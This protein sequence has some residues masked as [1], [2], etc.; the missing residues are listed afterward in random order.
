MLIKIVKINHLDN[1]YWLVP[2]IINVFHY[3]KHKSA[4]KYGASLEELLKKND[5]INKDFAINLNKDEKFFNFNLA[6]KLK[7][8]NFTLDKKIVEHVAQLKHFDFEILPNIIIRID[9]KMLY[10]IWDGFIPFY[11]S[12]YFQKLHAKFVPILQQDKIYLK[13]RKLTG[14]NIIKNPLKIS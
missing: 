13:W 5:L 6:Q 11:H 1:G 10:A 12:D 14:F 8:L 4:F 9:K 2:S 7:K 3:K